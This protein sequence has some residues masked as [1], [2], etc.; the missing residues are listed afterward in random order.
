MGCTRYVLTGGRRKLIVCDIIGFRTLE[1]REEIIVFPRNRLWPETTKQ[2]EDRISKQ[3]TCNLQ[4]HRNERTN[5]C[6]V[7]IRAWEENDAWSM[8]KRLGKQKVSTPP[9]LMVG[10]RPFS[11]VG[12]GCQRR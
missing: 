1:R 12:V 8:V 10:F 7:D 6:G 3:C 2:N 5:F 11:K 9:Q 4:I